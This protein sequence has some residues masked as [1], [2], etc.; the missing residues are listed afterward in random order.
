MFYSVS[1]GVQL[2]TAES[3]SVLIS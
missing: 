1:T 2:L 3:A